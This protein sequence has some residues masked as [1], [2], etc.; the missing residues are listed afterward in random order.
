MAVVLAAAFA[1]FSVAAC[2]DKSAD[3]GATQTAANGDTFN[4]ADVRFASDM[5]PHHAQAIQMVNM[6]MGRE[7]GPTAQELAEDVR[8]AQVPEIE[9]MVDWLTAWGKKIP[10]TATDHANAH[11][12]SG[13]E[14]HHDMPGMMSPEQMAKL[15]SADDT[16]FRDMWLEMMIEHHRG[17]IEVAQ[18]EQEDGV[19]GPAVKLAERI[20]AAQQREVETM[21]RLLRS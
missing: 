6:T 19:F 12:D 16:E 7:L 17:A 8:D 20:E 14:M 3:P 18:T 21:E 4:D 1:L 2:G 10:R 13:D 5:I 15:E 11:G 9:Q